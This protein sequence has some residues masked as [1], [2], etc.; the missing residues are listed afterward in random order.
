MELICFVH[1][2][3]LGAAHGPGRSGL[4]SELTAWANCTYSTAQLQWPE[5][6]VQ[7]TAASRMFPLSVLSPQG[8]S[9]LLKPHI[10]CTIAISVLDNFPLLLYVT[11]TALLFCLALKHPFALVYQEWYVTREI[12]CLPNFVGPN[13]DNIF[14]LFKERANLFRGT[15]IHGCGFF[16]ASG[17]II[18]FTLWHAWMLQMKIVEIHFI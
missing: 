1:P 11:G 8:L 6:A 15:R 14:R 10:N 7:V 17:C 18:F 12:L 16:G 9:L 2:F 3:S 4:W 5:L 13:F